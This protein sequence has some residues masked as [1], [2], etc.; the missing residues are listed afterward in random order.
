M[1]CVFYFHMNVI[2]LYLY[3]KSN[4]VFVFISDHYQIPRKYIQGLDKAPKGGK[5]K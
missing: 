3:K 4:I 1:V 5:K 2:L